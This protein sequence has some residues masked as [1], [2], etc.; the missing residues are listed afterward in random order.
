M[1][2]KQNGWV[3]LSVIALTNTPTS[4]TTVDVIA[5]Q[6]FV[7]GNGKLGPLSLGQSIATLPKSVPGL[8]EKYTYHKEKYEDDMDGEGVNE[9][10]LF[11]KGGKKIINANIE[12]GKIE[13]FWVKE[14]ASFIKTIDGFHI[15]SSARELFRKKPMQ[16]ETYF[17]GE[18]FGTSGGYTYNVNSDDVINKDVPERAEDFK[19]NAVISS[20]VYRK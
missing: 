3:S 14:G 17:M 1:T 5:T 19:Q 18:V 9:Y 6:E 16:W 7:L 12:N 4:N 11:I 13:S 20:I 2:E 15:G 10:I 8:Y